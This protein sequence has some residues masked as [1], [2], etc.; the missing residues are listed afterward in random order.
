MTTPADPNH[1][2]E[3]DAK[4]IVDASVPPALSDAIDGLI[5]ATVDKWTKGFS[6][7]GYDSTLALAQAL[8]ATMS[9][10]AM[11]GA[12]AVLKAYDAARKGAG[13]PVA[14]SISGGLDVAV[15]PPT[16]AIRALLAREPRLAASAAEVSRLYNTERVFSAAK[17]IETTVLEKVQGAIVEALR[18]GVTED[19]A[20]RVVAELADW[21]VGYSNTVFRNAAMQSYADGETATAKLPGVRD[22]IVGATYAGPTDDDARPNHKALVGFRAPIDDPR[23]KQIGPI[24]GHN[25]RHSKVLIDVF[26]AERSGWL[27]AVGNLKHMEIPAGGGPDEGF[28]PGG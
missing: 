26:H 6:V 25:C 28:R 10:A 19:V 14:E 12:S 2:P 23:W 15:V 4:K 13:W 20:G 21:K 17:A 27:D 16:E 9:D 11:T 22:V 3:R 7:Q 1:K 5:H 24:S 8:G 18:S